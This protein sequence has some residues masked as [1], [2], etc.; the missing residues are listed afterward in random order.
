MHYIKNFNYK[1]KIDYEKLNKILWL[2]K[3]E[4]KPDMKNE[5][6]F[7]WINWECLSNEAILTE[8]P[9]HK[10][11]EMIETTPTKTPANHRKDQLNLSIISEESKDNNF[12]DRIHDL[13][14]IIEENKLPC[15]KV[16]NSVKLEPISSLY[17][18]NIINSA[19]CSFESFQEPPMVLGESQQKHIKAESSSP[20]LDTGDVSPE[21]VSDK[22]KKLSLLKR[23]GNG[24]SPSMDPRE[25]SPEKVSDKVKKFDELMYVNT[26]TYIQYI[27]IYISRMKFIE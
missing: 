27:N 11:V 13:D 4:S 10:R 19:F 22:V 14:E 15:L 20:S 5:D 16:G 21:K 2:V 26:Y 1:E 12:S 23:V 17:D 18:R 8:S 24:S 9:I 6:L 3:E 7:E 25:F